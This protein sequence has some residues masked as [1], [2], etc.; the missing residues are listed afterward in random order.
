MRSRPALVK[1]SAGTGAEGASQAR[2]RDLG[3][4]AARGC[5]V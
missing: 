4:T 2:R 1:R 5:G 3:G